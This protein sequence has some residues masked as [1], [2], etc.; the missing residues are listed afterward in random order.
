VSPKDDDH[1]HSYSLMVNQVNTAAIF[2]LKVPKTGLF[3]DLVYLSLN[4]IGQFFY[5]ELLET[6]VLFTALQNYV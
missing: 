4:E 1:D 6:M 5:F 3:E 2:S